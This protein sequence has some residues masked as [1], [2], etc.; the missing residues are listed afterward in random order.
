MIQDILTL[1]QYAKYKGISVK[2]AYNWYKLGKI[3]ETII[4]KGKQPL[5]LI[6]TNN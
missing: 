3:T 1:S 4:Y 2:T 6:K 5:I